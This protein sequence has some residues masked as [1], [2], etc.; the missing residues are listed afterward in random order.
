[1]ELFGIVELAGA[2]SLPRRGAG[3][4]VFVALQ[5]LNT[6]ASACFDG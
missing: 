1:M 2:W 6:Q 4:L 3:A 5:E